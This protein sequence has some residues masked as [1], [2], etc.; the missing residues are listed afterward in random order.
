MTVT[1]VLSL[2]LLALMFL[3]G[4]IKGIGAFIALWLNF[5]IL[6]VMIFAISFGFNATWVLVLGGGTVLLITILST[7]ASEQVTANALI[8]AL[9]IM[10]LLTILI[11]P[12][13][14]LAMAQGFAEQNSEELEGLSLGISV[15]FVTIGVVAALLATLGAIAEAAVAIA[16]AIE[17]I[18]ESQPNMPF[19]KFMMASNRVGQQIVGTA[20]NTVLFGF[21]ADF[22]SLAI[23]FAKLNYNFAAIIN[24]KLFSSAMLSMLYAILGV[25]LVLPL[26]LALYRWQDYRKAH[27]ERLNK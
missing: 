10:V 11:F 15:S 21:M 8:I 17:E 7:G 1:I 24:S 18:R 23:W 19:K 6:V 27:S 14:H 16:T 4:G 26:M 25:V 9:T 20:V 2:I 12:L 5:A 13:E 22:L 3:V